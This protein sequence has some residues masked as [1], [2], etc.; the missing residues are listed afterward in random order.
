MSSGI[1]AAEKMRFAV[2]GSGE[3]S[4]LL[5]LPKDARFILALAHGAGAGMSHPFMN[6]LA[7]ELAHAGI[8]TLRYQFPYMEAR[9]GRP[10]SPAVAT[11]TVSAAVSTAAKLEPML[12]LLAGGK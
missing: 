2:P 5:L 10:D 8:A 6:A 9:K 7:Q 11:T 4:A 12:P 1:P 3:V